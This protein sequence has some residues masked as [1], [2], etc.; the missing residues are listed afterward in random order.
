MVY[1]LLCNPLPFVRSKNTVNENLPMICDSVKIKP[2][3]K[4]SW[5]T[6]YVHKTPG[7]NTSD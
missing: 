5:C 1:E 2:E 7:K 6:C 4:V 3:D